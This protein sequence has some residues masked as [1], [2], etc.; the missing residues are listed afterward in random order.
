MLATTA[1]D[2]VGEHVAI[3]SICED[4]ARCRAVV[5]CHQCQLYYCN[6]CLA[7]AHPERGLLKQVK[8]LNSRIENAKLSCSIDISF[9]TL[10]LLLSSSLSSSDSMRSFQS[11]MCRRRPCPT[12]TCPT[13][14]LQSSYEQQHVFVFGIVF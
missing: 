5:R 3:C 10:L 1:N 9:L 7:I 11:A 6:D 12:S 13:R 4:D 14:R 2:D 8:K